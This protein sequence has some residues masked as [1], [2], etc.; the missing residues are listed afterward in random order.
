[1]LSKFHFSAKVSRWVPGSLPLL[2]EVCTV[3]EGVLKRHVE[4]VTAQDTE[5]KVLAVT[6]S[7]SGWISAFSKARCYETEHAFLALGRGRAGPCTIPWLL[8][9]KHRQGH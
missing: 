7:D 2:P 9:A 1:M 4:G 5:G 3:V 8:L 6:V